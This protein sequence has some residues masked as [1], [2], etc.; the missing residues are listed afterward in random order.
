MTFTKTK[1]FKYLLN[2]SV[3][4]LSL[5]ALSSFV[6]VGFNAS[7]LAAYNSGSSRYEDTLTSPHQE[8]TY[9]YKYENTSPDAAPGYFEMAIETVLT[10]NPQDQIQINSISDSYPVDATT[11]ADISGVTQTTNYLV[12]QASFVDT[13]VSPSVIRIRFVP[14]K[15]CTVVTTAIT[16]DTNIS[17]LAQPVNSCAVADRTTTLSEPEKFIPASV[18]GRIAIKASLKTTAAIGTQILDAPTANII[19]PNG[20]NINSIGWRITTNYLKDDATLDPNSVPTATI[21]GQGG[22]GN[23]LVGVPYTVEVSNIKAVTGNN[24]QAPLGTCTTVVSGQTYTGTGISNGVCL[25][26]ITVNAG[27]TIAAGTANISDGGTPIAITRNNIPYNGVTSD[28]YLT[29]SDIPGLTVNCASAQVNS[30]TTCSF[31]L[32]ANKLLPPSPNNLR[33][34]INDATPAGS[35]TATGSNVL[36]T[37]VPTGTQAGSMP[38][39]GQIG[40]NAKVATGEFVTIGAADISAIDIPG[41][42]FTCNIAP[43]NATTTC[44]F[45]LPANKSLPSTFRIG[46]GDSTLAGLCTANG[47]F[48]TCLNT[49]TG[50][51]V[52][53]QIIFAQI[54]STTKTDTGEKTYI[55]PSENM[56]EGD[57]TYNPTQGGTAPLF[58]SSDLT[59]VTLSNFKTILDPNPT[60]GTYVCRFEVRPFQA[61]DSTASWVSLQQN[62]P[63]TSASGCS[64][65]FTKAIRGTGLNWSLRAIVSKVAEPSVTFEL[66]DSYVFRFQGAG[67]AS[68]G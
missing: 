48:V 22:N 47:A 23:P 2:L 16:A 67:I 15:P 6:L 50:S 38:I 14:Q 1:I 65:Q 62:V 54:G 58:R 4:Y 68:G 5:I 37:G 31:T 17:R 35:C 55:I 13:S 56:H 49:P 60:D 12:T 8:A 44:S 32:P 24:L 46:L 43:T 40:S 27:P 20:F 11:Y 41:I 3:K 9:F 36:C 64:S 34:G 30:T 33:F 21:K 28:S 29:D 26:N 39:F 7:V 61:N 10:A 57:F 51:L 18:P 25:I 52:G 45:I 19:F 59:T 63:Y 53:N 42:T 66:R